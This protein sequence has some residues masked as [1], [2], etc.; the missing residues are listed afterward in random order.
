MSE[1]KEYKVLKDFRGAPEG[2]TVVDFQKDQVVTL[3]VEFGER[4]VREK[5]L[6][7]NKAPQRKEGEG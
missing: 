4:M 3:P 1:R 2:H 5:A 7:E 6:R